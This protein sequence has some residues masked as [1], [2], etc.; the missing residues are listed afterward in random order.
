M[1]HLKVNLQI[2]AV[3]IVL[4]VAQYISLNGFLYFKGRKLNY[5]IYFL[6]ST[7]CFRILHV[8]F[9]IHIEDSRVSKFQQVCPPVCEKKTLTS[10][11]TV[12][13]RIHI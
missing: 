8:D 5:K 12:R 3:F 2:S 4:R 13:N 9:Y 11:L 7:S 6:N 1:V 10:F